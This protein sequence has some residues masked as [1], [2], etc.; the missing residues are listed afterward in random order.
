MPRLGLRLTPQRHILLE[1]AE[2][3]PILDDVIAER[4][5]DAFARGTGHGLMRLGACEV[6]QVLSP[7]FA[8]WRDIAARFLDQSDI[9]VA[10]YGS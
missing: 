3:A 6:G 4:L 8:W 1:A 5:A 9:A 2:D 10:E 7:T